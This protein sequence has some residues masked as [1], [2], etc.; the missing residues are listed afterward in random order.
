MARWENFT[1]WRGRLPHW[2][3]DNVCY[4]ATFRHRR[5]LDASERDI[6]FREV[7]KT[8]MRYLETDIVVVLPEST[9]LI[10]R[11]KTD[12]DGRP[13][14]LS[15]AIEKAKTRAG[16]RI[17]KVTGERFPPFYEESFDRILRDELEYE[18]FWSEI[19][20]SP[21]AAELVESPEDYGTLYVAHAPGS[22]P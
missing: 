19:L 16:K 12:R 22:E 13:A 17:I 7:R 3:A 1:V 15:D 10:F 4:F 14:E 9:S 20:E 6:L 8:E 18:A 11:V 2:R 21:V 5:P